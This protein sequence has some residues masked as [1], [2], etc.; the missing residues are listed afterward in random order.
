MSDKQDII[1]S[2]EARHLLEHP[3]YKKIVEGMKDATIEKWRSCDKK[4]QRDDYWR[5]YNVLALFEETVRIFVE[6][7]VIAKQ[8][9]EMQANWAQKMKSKF[10][11]EKQYG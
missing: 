6:R 9:Q 11:G 2:D 4:E 1:D 10:T 7:G 3:A 8:T 5:L